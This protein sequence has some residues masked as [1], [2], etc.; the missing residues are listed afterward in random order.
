MTTCQNER[1]DRFEDNN[2][3]KDRLVDLILNNEVVPAVNQMELHPFCQ[4]EDLRKVM[5]ESG[6]DHCNTKICSQRKDRREL[7]GG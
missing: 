7:C 2:F 3:E 6:K 1:R 4:Q 5:A